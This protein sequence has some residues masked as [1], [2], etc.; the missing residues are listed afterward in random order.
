M[1]HFRYIALMGAACLSFSVTSYAQCPGEAPTGSP[2]APRIVSGQP[3]AHSVVMDLTDALG[4]H[5]MSC[6]F[7]VGRVV[8]FQVT[9]DIDGRLTFNSC[10]PS[11]S[12]DTVIQPWRFA[13]DC[14]FPV[15]LD[16]FCVDDTES[17]ACDNGCSAFG[18]SVTFLATAG[19]TYLF[20]GRPS[21]AP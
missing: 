9:P 8:W 16:D 20:L 7:N 15:R 17:A 2:C 13:G 1:A 14:E 10:H 21:P 4:S 11:T 5:Q 3:G 19:E 18:G 12:F 6:G